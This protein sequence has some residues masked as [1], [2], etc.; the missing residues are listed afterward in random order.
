MAQQGF[1][2]P[3]L[4][5]GTEVS[6]KYRGAFCEAKVKSVVRVV[7][8]RV[9][10][11][12]GQSSIFVN[13]EEIKGC[14]KLGAAVEVKHPESSQFVE[15]TIN[16]LIDHSSYTVVF[17]DGDERTLRRSQLCLKGDKHFIES[18]TLDNLPLSHPE[19]FGTPVLQNKKAKR[20]HDDESDEEVESSEEESPRRATYRGRHQELVGKLMLVDLPQ[21]K[22]TLVPALVVLPDA[23]SLNE[24][25]NRDQ[26]LVRSFKDSKFMVVTR[27]DLKDFSRAAVIKIED[28]TLRTAIEKALLYFDTK[29]LPV[30]WNKE[31]MLGSD[32]DEDEG[33]EENEYA[34]EDEPF[35]EKDR[36]VAQLYK[37]M[38]DRGTP[39]NKGPCI[40]NKD[41][42]LYKLF[43]IVQNLGGYNKVTKEMK[44]AVVYSKMG[45]PSLHQN[46]AHQIKTAYKK[47]LDAYETFYRKLGSTMGTLSRP[48]R[49]RQ[50]S[51]R[52]ILNFR[53]RERSPRSPK[54]PEKNKDESEATKRKP[55][56]SPEKVEDEIEATASA[57]DENDVVTRR[58]PRR[59]TK[60]QLIKDENKER[61]EDAVKGNKEDKKEDVLKVKK[62]DKKDEKG[63]KNTP[64]PGLKAKEDKGKDDIKKEDK[65]PVRKL[66]GDDESEKEDKKPEKMTKKD[67]DKKVEVK[68]ENSPNI[69]IEK[70]TP[71]KRVTRRKLLPND[72][73]TDFETKEEED[74]K[75]LPKKMPVKVG[76]KPLDKKDIPK[77][78]ERREKST[79]KKESIP[80]K[81][82]KSGEKKPKSV[83]EK[84]IKKEKKGKEDNTDEA[85]ETNKT[86]LASTNSEDEEETETEKVVSDPKLDFPIGSKLRVKYGRGKNQKIYIA[87]VV[88]FGKDGVHKTY[89]VHY[90]GWN[91]RYDEWIRPDRVVSVLDK[92]S[93]G[94]ENKNKMPNSRPPK[95]M[96]ALN[97]SNLKIASQVFRTPTNS[98]AKTRATRSSSS[99][100][101]VVS[102]S[103]KMVTRR[104][105]ILA[106]ST[107]SVSPE[108][109][110][111]S[112]AEDNTGS[113]RAD[114]DDDNTKSEKEDEEEDILNVDEEFEDETEGEKFT[115]PDTSVEE[116]DS[117]L[118]ITSSD[119]GSERVDNEELEEQAAVKEIVD[120][121]SSEDMSADGSKATTESKNESKD[122]AECTKIAVESCRKSGSHDSK[123][124]RALVLVSEINHAVDEIRSAVYEEVTTKEEP[125]EEIIDSI[126]ISA[127]TTETQEVKDICTE[128]NS[129]L[130][131]EKI[132][133]EEIVTE[134]PIQQNL[135]DESAKLD[136]SFEQEKKD[137][138]KP[139]SARGRKKEIVA[140]DVKKPLKT[141]MQVPALSSE[142]SSSDQSVPVVDK[143][144]PS[145]YDFDGDADVPVWQPE[146]TKKWEPSS[147]VQIKDPTSD[148]GDEKE[149][150]KV[151]KKVKRKA[152]AEVESVEENDMTSTAGIKEDSQNSSVSADSSSDKTS[153]KKKGRKK[154]ELIN[155]TKKEVIEQYESTV[156]SVVEAVK[157]SLLD[158][159]AVKHS[160]LDTEAEHEPNIKRRRVKRA[161]ESDK[162][163]SVVRVNK[164]GRKVASRDCLDTSLSTAG[165]D[166]KKE[167]VVNS[168][169]ESCRV[170]DTAG[171]SVL[172]VAD[173]EGT[174][175]VKNRRK[176]CS[177]SES[178][179]FEPQAEQETSAPFDNTPPTTPEHDEDTNNSVQP[180]HFNSSDLNSKLD[181][182]KPMTTSLSSTSLTAPCSTL[183]PSKSAS[184][185]PSDNDVTST[186]STDN[187]DGL[188]VPTA[189]SESSGTDQDVPVKRRRVME[190]T[191]SGPGSAKKKK[192]IHGTRSRTAQKSP[193]YVGNSDSQGSA[194]NTPNHCPESPPNKFPDM[195]KSPRPSKFNFSADL[196]EYLEGEAR[197]NFLISK[198]R[199][200][201][202]I[203]MNLKAEVASIDR[204]RKRAKR[205]ERESSQISASEKEPST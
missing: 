69:T 3:S 59:D 23:N 164:M 74:K 172:S 154:K 73:K 148:E 83:D 62:E 33:E 7:K 145:P 127:G 114:D 54:P 160:L 43:K 60:T 121:E 95:S 53:G 138:E 28:K 191:A 183:A 193:K 180:S 158:T 190:E 200:I 125:L 99:D 131:E 77:T 142:T 75:E 91:T 187:F 137:V 178:Q 32:L 192:R 195:S 136:S 149:K 124:E 18:E 115:D 123:P 167:P 197:C 182:S 67:E 12:D 44:W 147:K 133:G 31:E 108:S 188:L 205:K 151:K 24:V 184:E 17:D 36:F 166:N 29:E 100:T 97:Q 129:D 10:V 45:L 68:P 101:S 21:R 64:V 57:V 126:D 84:R 22:G 144:E 168:N 81:E 41:L 11:K 19:H 157:H 63:K 93:D 132:Q 14:V 37:F 161:S 51:S 116:A 50:N 175:G 198:M 141:D 110:N 61:K 112:D 92:P 52:S 103:D 42:N 171:S 72:L 26:I 55:E 20:K 78:L 82:I 177:F 202:S 16:K 140:K 79:E 106:D 201:K 86:I 48:G 71:K 9:V 163:D 146:I 179:G 49:A 47:Y 6:A 88:D 118:K 34:S 4:P 152:A 170:I 203:Y 5:V 120:T 150:K 46:P 56:A 76:E 176:E 181:L 8:C 122:K 98:G 30:G 165:D 94:G 65:K 143:T 169:T 199:E 155:E 128:G 119:A 189:Q 96:K 90:A 89:L 153:S 109:R 117:G 174:S 194:S 159:D 135:N 111:S 105:S 15:A 40:G 2:P 204:R 107:G 156:N 35:E 102:K 70:E 104:R 130:H 173:M 186:A 185:S 38:D 13:D 58:T 66:K 134:Q 196:G 25:K 1:G 162:R 85:S 80:K 113:E 87:K 139:K 27:K 39:I